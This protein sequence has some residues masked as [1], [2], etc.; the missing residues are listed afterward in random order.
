[1]VRDFR[2]L[3]VYGV[4]PEELSRY[5]DDMEAELAVDVVVAATAE[6]V[7]R[8]SDVVVCA[9]PAREPYLQAHWL[10]PGLHITSMGSDMPGKQELFAECFARADRVACDRVSQCVVIGE[11]HHVVDAG[12][13]DESRVDELGEITAGMKPGR[14][15]DDEIT[16]CDLTGVGVQDT[17]I[18]RLAY[19]RALAA[20]L[21]TSFGD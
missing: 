17:A 7:V 3:Y 12:L 9:T 20:G 21:G 11:L 13:L 8:E 15:G 4:V 1:M 16:I 5:V 10:H 19:R 6:S 14:Q 18:A 2:R